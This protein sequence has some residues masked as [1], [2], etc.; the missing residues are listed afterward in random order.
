[1]TILLLLPPPDPAALPWITAMLA[2]LG[3]MA[4]H[5]LLPPHDPAIAEAL[6]LA[7]VHP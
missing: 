4:L 6:L 7:S 3:G 5:L 1:M 2:G